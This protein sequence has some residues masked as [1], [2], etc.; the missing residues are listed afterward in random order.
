MSLDVKSVH[1]CYIFLFFKYCNK[2]AKNKIFIVK[3]VKGLQ[4]MKVPVVGSNYY[5][6]LSSSLHGGHCTL[7][8]IHTFINSVCVKLFCVVNNTKRNW[9]FLLLYEYLFANCIKVILYVFLSFRLRLLIAWLFI[10]VKLTYV[11]SFCKSK[12]V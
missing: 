9:F 1:H 10:S 3:R 7:Y 4:S 6:A 2:L 12:K 8:C 11:C 5:Q